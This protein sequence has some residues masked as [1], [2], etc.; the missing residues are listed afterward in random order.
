MERKQYT[1]EDKIAYYTARATQCADIL[2]TLMHQD[3]GP[4][5][6]LIRSLVRREFKRC[7]TRLTSLQSDEY[8]DWNSDLQ[9]QLDK[10]KKKA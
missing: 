10:Y 2:A 5:Q 6:E 7:E 3:L 1:R 9:K 4:A 8:Q